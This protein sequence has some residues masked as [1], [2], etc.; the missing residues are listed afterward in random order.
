MCDVH[1]YR[2]TNVCLDKVGRHTYWCLSEDTFLHHL[3]LMSEEQ[4]LSSHE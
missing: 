4:I 3:V 1:K 2:D